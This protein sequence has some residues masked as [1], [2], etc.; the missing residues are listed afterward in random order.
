MAVADGGASR[1]NKEGSSEPSQF[2]EVDQDLTLVGLAM[3]NALALNGDP[4][5][6]LLGDHHY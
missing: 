5:A 3:K 6:A 4:A 2:W 1:T